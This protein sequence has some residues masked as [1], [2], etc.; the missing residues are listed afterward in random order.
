QVLINLLKNAVESTH[1]AGSKVSVSWDCSSDSVTL[2]ILDQ[3]DG[4]ANPDNLFIP[5][6]S[7]KP[8]GSGIGLTLS[9]QII[10]NHGG[11]LT[12]ENRTDGLP[13]ARA[14]IRIPLG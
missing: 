8:G 2:V 9:R 3:G 12:L 10:E 4:I 1:E 11:E 14:A 6:F 5:F 13:G 7:T